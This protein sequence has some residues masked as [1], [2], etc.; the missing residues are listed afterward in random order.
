[1]SLVA[2]LWISDGK[3]KF[4]KWYI[5]EWPAIW[6][7]IVYTTNYGL[8]FVKWLWA[9]NQSGTNYTDEEMREMLP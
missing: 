6:E 3:P 4:D 2:L 5:L 8:E 1:M 9:V 7:Y